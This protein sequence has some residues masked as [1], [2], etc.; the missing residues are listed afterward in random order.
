[1]QDRAAKT[2]TTILAIVADALRLWLR[3][4]P[5]SSLGDARTQIENVL[6]DEFADVAHFAR[7]ERDI[8][9]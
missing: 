8:L 1:M 4:N 9:D 6:R 5:G 2:A 7:G 3:G